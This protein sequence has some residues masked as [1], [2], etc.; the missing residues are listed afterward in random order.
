MALKVLTL[1]LWNDSG[2]W[3]ARRSLIR[4]WIRRL[5]PDL[6][7]FQEALSGPSCD[8]LDE[9]VGDMAFTTAYVGASRFWRDSSLQFGNAI[10]SRWPIAE[11]HELE[12]PNAGDS[13]TRAAV[14]ALIDAPVPGGQLCFSSTHLSWK[15]EHGFIRE[16]Q[17]VALAEHVR[18]IAPRDGFP[19][20]VAGDFN[21]E[22]DSDEI[23][24]LT[25]LHS[26]DGRSVHFRDAWRCSGA[27]GQGMTWSNR[28]DYARACFEFDR[29]IDYVFSG[30]PML[31][32]SGQVESCRVVCDQVDGEVWPSDHFGL[33]AELRVV[34]PGSDSSP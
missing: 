9:L 4:S 30:P 32:G 1:N 12:L 28:N 15:F 26:I 31:G 5:D 10:A 18:S 33:L 3:P 34:T 22:P 23:R 16:R 17:V 27:V 20:I 8:Q 6:I 14:T 11:R 7:A 2:P 29:R 21:A 19:P 25:G 24:Y 13:E